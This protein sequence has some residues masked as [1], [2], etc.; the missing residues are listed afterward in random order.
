M[1][2]LEL[3]SKWLAASMAGLAAE[4]DEGIRARVMEYCG[5]ACALHFGSIETVRAIR[6]SV[7]DIDELLDELNQ[8][9]GLWCGRWVRDEGAISSVCEECGC[10]LARAGLVELSPTLCYC[11][12]GWVKAV[13]EA[14]LGGPVQ[15]ELE[16]AIGRGDQV[17]RFIVLP[18][19]P[20][21]G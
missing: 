12:R 15:V 7:K 3:L 17:C 14:A 13:F 16:Q 20:S 19:D 21:E 10:P 18:G 11:S 2:E 1:E 6:S 8:Q 9:K 5:R 4:V